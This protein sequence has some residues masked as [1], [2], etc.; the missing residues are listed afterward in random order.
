MMRHHAG[1]RGP[2]AIVGVPTALGGHL[3]GMELTPARAACRRAASRPCGRDRALA[4]V[5]MRDAGDLAIEPGFRPDP[6][7]RAK[8]R[9]AICEFLPR[10]RDLVAAAVVSGRP[11][12]P[13]RTRGC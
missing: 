5:E 2:I 7:P 4:R 6:D 8:N 1:M 3:S 10:E 9:A 11:A 13:P 12:A